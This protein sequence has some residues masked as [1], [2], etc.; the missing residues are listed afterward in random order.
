MLFRATGTPLGLA[1]E[2]GRGAAF[3]VAL[4]LSVGEWR[5]AEKVEA[6]IVDLAPAPS[7]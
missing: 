7:S 2:K 6:Q 5:G 4:R 1:L 3:H